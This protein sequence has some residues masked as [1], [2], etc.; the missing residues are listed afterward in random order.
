M[1]RCDGVQDIELGECFL[2]AFQIL[3][4]RCAFLRC[5]G[6]LLVKLESMIE[7]QQRLVEPRLPLKDLADVDPDVDKIGFD[8]QSQV[9]T[10][11]RLIKLVLTLQQASE[12]GKI[13]WIVRI[14]RY[15]LRDQFDGLVQ[16]IVSG[17]GHG[18]P[19]KAIRMLSWVSG[20][21]QCGAI[22]LA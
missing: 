5:F 3:E 1:V 12:I 14:E 22:I 2:K 20:E 15:G 21:S 17:M 9:V 18:T 11:E 6:A 19:M 4:Q 13:I 7:S 8:S 16:L 10:L